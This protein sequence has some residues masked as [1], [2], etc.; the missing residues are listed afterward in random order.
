M[1]T[2]VVGPPG[3]DESQA[4]LLIGVTTVLHVLSWPLYLAR[5]WARATPTFRLQVDDYL[6]TAAMVGRS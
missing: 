5:I 6:I 4:G 1:A 3:P 2:A